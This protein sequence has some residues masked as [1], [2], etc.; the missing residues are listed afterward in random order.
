MNC[1]V[2]VL[3]L[4]CAPCPA[5]REKKQTVR[6]HE[7]LNA[8]RAG[9]AAF[10]G[11]LQVANISG[12]I[13][14]ETVVVGPAPEDQP[15]SEAEE[16][17]LLLQPG[18]EDLSEFFKGQKVIEGDDNADALRCCCSGKS[19]PCKLA[20]QSYLNSKSKNLFNWVPGVEAG[21]GALG[22][23]WHS[24][25]NGPPGREHKCLVESI[26]VEEHQDLL[27]AAALRPNPDAR[28]ECGADVVVQADYGEDGGPGLSVRLPKENLL[29]EPVEIGRKLKDGCNVVYSLLCSGT[30]GTKRTTLRQKVAPCGK[31]QVDGCKRCHGPDGDQKD[32]D[33]GWIR[34]RSTKA[35][36]GLFEFNQD[37]NQV[38]AGGHLKDAMEVRFTPT[39][40]TCGEKI[41]STEVEK[42]LSN[43]ETEE[44]V[45]AK[46]KANVAMLKDLLFTPGCGGDLVDPARVAAKKV[47]A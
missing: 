25:N 16:E 14:Q 10:R 23:G 28:D 22:D 40:T 12:D 9:R 13:A 39:T 29:A 36:D 3:V 33:F 27:D 44:F 35:K 5:M 26:K 18:A 19:G 31:E 2:M 6:L 11:G 20:T 32:V 7:G 46:V 34:T 8:G 30:S 38:Y 4:S 45:I 1:V 43:I 21:C 24:W 37:F 17:V 42:A 15:L 47:S 41:E